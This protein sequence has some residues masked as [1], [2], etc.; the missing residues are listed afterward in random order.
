[1]KRATVLA[2]LITLALAGAAVAAQPHAQ[3]QKGARYDGYLHRDGMTALRKHLRIVVAPTGK[4]AQLLWWCGSPDTINNRQL[5]RFPIAPD[6]TFENVSRV[7]SRQSGA[8]RGASSPPPRR[9]S[10]FASSPPATP[11]AASPR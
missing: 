5:A 3:P 1:M 10:S 4:T 2:L 8:R 6:G 11:R 7:G 9:G